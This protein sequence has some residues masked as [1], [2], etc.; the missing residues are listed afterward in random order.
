MKSLPPEPP[1]II[2][3]GRQMGCGGRELGQLLASRL[4]I[5]YFDKELLHDAARA[6]GMTATFLE[7]KDEH[8]PSF[9]SGVLSF[10]FG[11]S[12][13][14]FYATP[15][16]ISDDRLYAIQSDYIRH[17]GEHT[18][19]VIVGRTADYILRDH[20]RCVNVFLHASE[21]DC[22]RRIMRRGDVATEAEARALAQRTNKI[23]ASY[24]NF[25]T[26]RKW[27]RASTYDL[28]I[29]TSLMSMEQVAEVILF[30]IRQR[31]GIDC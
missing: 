18:S 19:C 8:T 4:G 31:Y 24:Y 13:V 25:Y 26:D 28:T 22:I 20:P 10:T 11:H 3:I 7:D 14:N 2:T 29:N 17:L 30:Y 21:A 23:R 15:S 5:G 27:G 16:A 12:P 9:L 1:L 6:A